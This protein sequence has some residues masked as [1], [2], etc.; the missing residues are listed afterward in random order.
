MNYYFFRIMNMCT[1]FLG[2]ETRPL[3]CII[4]VYESTLQGGHLASMII[5]VYESTLQGG[6]PTRM[7]QMYC[8]YE[9]DT[10]AEGQEYEDNCIAG[11]WQRLP[12]HYLCRLRYDVLLLLVVLPLQSNSG[13]SQLFEALGTEQGARFLYREQ[14]EVGSQG[15]QLRLAKRS[16]S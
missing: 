3:V 2:I 7:I 10:G 16:Y 13:G 4:G 14:I 8:M 11:V 15:A 1:I 12:C 5:G 9:S 6:H